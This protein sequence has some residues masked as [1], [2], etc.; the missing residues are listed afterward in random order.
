MFKGMQCISLPSEQLKHQRAIHSSAAGDDSL[1][2][3]V[4][5]ESFLLT[6]PLRALLDDCC[7]LF[8]AF[9]SPFLRLLAGLAT[10]R[11]AAAAAYAY[12]Q[13]RTGLCA[14]LQMMY[15]MHLPPSRQQ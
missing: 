3:S 15:D 11:S 8:P 5:D 9:A 1:A 13:V 10:G 12:L 4:W 14:T 2:S 7:Q 6:A